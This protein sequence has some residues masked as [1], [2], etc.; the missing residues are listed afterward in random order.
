[1]V[2]KD[3]LRSRI[4]E[5]EEGIKEINRIF[6]KPFENLSLDEKYSVRYQIIII[7]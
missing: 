5:I 6:S 2:E 4:K 1:M 3:Y 7:A